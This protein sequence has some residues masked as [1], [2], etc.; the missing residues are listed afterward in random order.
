MSNNIEDLIRITLPNEKKKKASHE[1]E[2]MASDDDDNPEGAQ[3]G[4]KKYRIFLT[5]EIKEAMR[6]KKAKAIV[7]S[8]KWHAG[9]EVSIRFE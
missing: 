4:D 1:A 3:S 9:G 6:Q 8:G 7:V 5:P 2:I